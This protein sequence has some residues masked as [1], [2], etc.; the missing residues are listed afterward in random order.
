MFGIPNGNR[1]VFSFYLNF[2]DISIFKGKQGD[3]EIPSLHG[4]YKKKNLFN[5]K[6]VFPRLNLN[7][8]KSTNINELKKQMKMTPLSIHV[9]ETKK[10]SSNK[11]NQCK[12]LI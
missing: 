10:Y 5:K 2:S 4:N 9:F 3:S 7:I 1:C 8:F 12:Y 11:I 6:M